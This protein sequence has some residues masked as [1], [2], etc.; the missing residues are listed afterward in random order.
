MQ[1][2]Y[3]RDTW[4]TGINILIVSQATK[5][6]VGHNWVHPSEGRSDSS[7]QDYTINTQFFS[8]SIWGRRKISE[9]FFK[10]RTEQHGSLLLVLQ[11][12][13]TI[14]A[15]GAALVRLIHRIHTLGLG[16]G[17]DCAQ[18]FAVGFTATPLTRRNLKHRP[19]HPL[20]LLLMHSWSVQRP[21]PH[22]QCS[23]LHIFFLPTLEQMDSVAMQRARLGSCK[24]TEPQQEKK[25]KT[26][27][28][29]L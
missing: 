28:V 6:P 20:I 8:I 26:K 29:L 10:S 23:F 27:Q 3:P 24:I 16:T 18:H 21:P 14:F 17:W 22:L 4:T 15:D 25:T 5:I 9:L 12:S 2:I 19:S 11:P 13:L 1:I 7:Q